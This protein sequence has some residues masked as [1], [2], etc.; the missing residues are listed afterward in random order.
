M[1]IPFVQWL[2]APLLGGSGWVACGRQKPTATVALV[3]LFAVSPLS[4]ELTC[5]RSEEVSQHLEPGTH[6]ARLT[7]T[8]FTR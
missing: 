2:P 6:P 5:V 4:A 8:L 3:F 1:V 7:S